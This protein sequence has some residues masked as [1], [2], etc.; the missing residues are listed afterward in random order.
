[1]SH[2][3]V[4]VLAFALF[5]FPVH[6]DAEIIIVGEHR[7]SRFA[8]D[9]LEGVLN[10]IIGWVSKHSSYQNTHVIP[11]I[12]FLSPKEIDPE[13]RNTCPVAFFSWDNGHLQISS[14]LDVLHNPL[15]ESV[16]VH[17]IVHYL[18]MLSGKVF[19]EDPWGCEENLALE[20]EAYQLQREYY[21]THGGRLLPIPVPKISCNTQGRLEAVNLHH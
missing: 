20:S 12:E 3:K 10:D 7:L 19:R 18:Q 8:Q 11:T 5:L 1:M 9:D 13:C 17:E 14:E 6:A 21:R 15:H 4:A 2:I 16:V